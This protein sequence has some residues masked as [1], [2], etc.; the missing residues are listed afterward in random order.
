LARATDDPEYVR[1][2][3]ADFGAVVV[4]RMFGGAGIYA[5][6]TMFAIA[7][8]GVIY[9]KA[10]EQTLPAFEREGLPP[11]TYIAKKK[12]VS[13]SYWRMPDRLYDD[14]EELAEWSRHAMAAARRSAASK[15]LGRPAKAKTRSPKA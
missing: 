9:L 13:M 6:G 15:A 8:D 12:R 5:D 11:F 1:E 2:L 7:L 10:D 14:P 4:R 3:F